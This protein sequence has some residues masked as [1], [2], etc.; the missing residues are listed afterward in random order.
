MTSQAFVREVFVHYG[1]VSYESR[2]MTSPCSVAEFIGTIVEDHAREHFV[3]LFLDARNHLIGW[4][5]VSIGTADSSLVHAREIFQPA[6]LKGSVSIIL[7]HTH[8]S[9]RVEPSREDLLVTERI[10]KAGEILGIRLMDH[11]VVSL[12]EKRPVFYSMRDSDPHLLT[13]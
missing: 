5:I 10:A 4:Q 7:S 12:R 1:P 11:V 3:V 13:T 6:I 2:T 9:G 8:P